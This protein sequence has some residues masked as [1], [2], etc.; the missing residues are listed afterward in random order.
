MQEQELTPREKQEVKN[1]EQTRPGRY[2]VPDVD[3]FEDDTGLHIF[4]DMPGVDESSVE[5]ELDDDVLTIEGRVSLQEYEGL[6]PQ[7]S[8]YNI[9][10]YVRRFSLADASSFDRDKVIARM[11]NGVLQIELPKAEKAK[12]RKIAVVAS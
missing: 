7:Y 3:I 5:V 1:S 11:S 8:E 9:G 12:L 10:N 2:Y 4:A 6:Q